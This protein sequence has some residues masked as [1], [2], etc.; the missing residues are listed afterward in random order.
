MLVEVCVQDLEAAVFAVKAGADRLELCEN[1]VVGGLSPSEALVRN[2]QN[3]TDIPVHVLVRP[4][5]GGF[6]YTAF[7]YETILQEIHLYK[8]LGVAGIVI[9]ILKE[10]QTI[11]LD[12]I[13]EIRS[14]TKD[15]HLTF[16]RAFDQV[17][18][19]MHAIKV[20]EDIGVN[21][22]L[23]SG[24]QPTA[25]EGLDLLQ[26]LKELAGDLIIMPGA[27]INPEN[28]NTFKVAGFSAIHFSGT[29]KVG[30]A[31]DI[32]GTGHEHLKVKET[33]LVFEPDW[34]RL[35]INCVK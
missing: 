9:G 35:M 1:L 17:P 23:T 3:S 28:I 8:R 24:Q 2:I 10:D 21:T 22:I 19:P 20:L 31:L 6:V 27:G 12:R 13:R 26:D 15:L 4:R 16:H 34:V 7:E 32:P 18:D 5:D 30:H 29:R 33:K 11:D 25:L 14:L